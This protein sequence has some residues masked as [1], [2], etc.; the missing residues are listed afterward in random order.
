MNYI[1]T[2][3]TRRNPEALI[4]IKQVLLPCTPAFLPLTPRKCSIKPTAPRGASM[5][6]EVS[7]CI[8]RQ[9]SEERTLENLTQTAVHA[10]KKAKFLL[11]LF[12]LKE[13]YICYHA[14]NTN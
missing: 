10:V 3:M 9:G 8:A 2:E 11:V 13:K 14:K 12:F 4:V 1:P 5:R 6:P 7:G